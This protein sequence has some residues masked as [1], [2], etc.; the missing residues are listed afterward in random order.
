MCFILEFV[1]YSFL[2][3]RMF[4]DFTVYLKYMFHF[5]KTV[6][7][8]AIFPNKTMKTYKIW[9]VSDIFIKIIGLQI[10]FPI[11]VVTRKSYHLSLTG[12]AQHHNSP[13]DRILH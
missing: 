12:P 13:C 5:Q 10:F 8:S 11:T 3:K 2:V 1:S 6:N 9:T 4:R 7:I